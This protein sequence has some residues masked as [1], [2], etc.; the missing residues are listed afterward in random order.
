MDTPLDVCLSR[1][2]QRDVIERGRK[3]E[4]VL[5]QYQ[6]TVRHHVFPIYRAF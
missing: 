2:I 3:I 6:Q 1:R 5:T 4:A